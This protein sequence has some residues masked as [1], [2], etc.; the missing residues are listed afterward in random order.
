MIDMLNTHFQAECIP[1]SSQSI[2]EAMILFKGRSSMKQYMPLKPI[3]RGYKVWVRSDST[4]GYVYMFE[5]CTGKEQKGLREVGLGRRVVR[6]LCQSLAKMN[7]HVRH[8]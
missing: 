1:S 6:R 3:K 4:T 2:D 7:V 8:L 5:V